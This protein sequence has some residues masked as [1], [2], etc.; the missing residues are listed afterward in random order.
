MKDQ[1]VVL[2][3]N[4]KGGIAIVF[5]TGEVPVTEVAKRDIPKGRPFKYMDGQSL[6][7]NLDDVQADFSNPDGFGE[8]ED[9]IDAL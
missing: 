1:T 2:Y 4:D 7:S 3:P 6:P 5:P 9:I 8:K